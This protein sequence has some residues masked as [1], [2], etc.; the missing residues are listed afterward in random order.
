MAHIPKPT[1]GRVESGIPQVP[2]T[3]LRIRSLLPS[4][5][6]AERRV[7]QRIIDDP[8]RA[9]ASSITQLAKDCATSE[10]TVIRFCRTI[11]FSGYRELRLALATE[12]GQARGARTTGGPEPDGDINPD[13]TLVTVVQKIAYTDARAV[14]ETGAALD[15]DVLRTVIDTMAAARRI[16]VYGV[17]ASAFVGADL[18]QKLHRIGLTSF[19]WSDAHVMLTSAALLDGRDVAIGISHSGATIDTVQ[20]LTEAGRRGAR[21]VAITNFPRSPIGFADHVL[22]TAA[23]ET[24]FRSGA[25]ASR[26]A[27]LTVVDCLFVGLAQSRYADSRTALETTA[28][29]V[30]GLRINDDR[31]RRR[32]RPDD[33]TNDD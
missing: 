25:T 31:K 11:D 26:L 30:R 20:A 9:A 5:A 33:K 1:E 21:T 10:A 22:T 8:E 14:E 17:G 6:P 28:D 16:D 27:Q 7:A 32:G 19:A 4:L 24:T 15:V 29:A 13:D 23:R 18:Q 2:T 12:A 3:V